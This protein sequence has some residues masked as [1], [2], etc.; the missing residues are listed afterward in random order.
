MSQLEKKNLPAVAETTMWLEDVEGRAEWLAIFISEHRDPVKDVV[1]QDGF[2]EEEVQYALEAAQELFAQVSPGCPKAS[3][4]CRHES[5]AEFPLVEYDYFS[6]EESPSS[7]PEGAHTLPRTVFGPDFDELTGLR[8]DVDLWFEIGHPNKRPVP[9]ADLLGN[10][11]SARAQAT[12]QYLIATERQAGYLSQLVHKFAPTEWEALMAAKR[13]GAW[14]TDGKQNCFMGLATIWKL[15][16]EAH[17]DRRDYEL[18]VITCGGE[19][20]GGDLYLP[21]LGVRIR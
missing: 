1:R 3:G 5:S 15:Q 10:H 11:G 17:L 19:F 20:Y 2:Y 4:D 21:N 12:R 13:K 9:S 18:A 6:E 8:H 14:Y 7:P 16:V